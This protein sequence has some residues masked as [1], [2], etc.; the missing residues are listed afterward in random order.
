MAPG[1][2]P[3]SASGRSGGRE[4]TP[5]LVGDALEHVTGMV[6]KEFDLFRAELQENMNKAFAAIA[7]IVIGI[8]VI[9][10]ALNVLA[11]ALVSWITASGLDAGWAALIVGGGLAVIG[12]GLAMKGKSDL[13][14]A[15]LAPTRSASNV[16]RDANT[17]KEATTN[18]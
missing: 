10:V 1:N 5:Q 7:M 17:V 11:A 12:I 4:S 13:Q 9:L 2:S 18:A 15:N 6:R 8:V 16:R 3:D 14:L